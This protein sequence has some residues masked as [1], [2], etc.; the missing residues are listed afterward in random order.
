[1]AYAETGDYRQ[2]V[3]WQQQAIAAAER[4]DRDTGMRQEMRENLTLFERGAPCRTPWA[5]YAMP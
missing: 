1:M 4:T 5:P 2:A 3:A